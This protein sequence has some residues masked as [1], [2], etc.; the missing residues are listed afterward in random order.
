ME[1]LTAANVPCS[2][3][4]DI[5]TA[6]ADPQALAREMVQ[7]ID[8]PVTGRIPLLGPV[9]KLSGTPAK[10]RRALPRFWVNIRKVCCVNYLGI[11][12]K[13][14]SSSAP[15]GSFEFLV[16]HVTSYLSHRGGA[17]IVRANYRWLSYLTGIS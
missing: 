10:I 11:V 3:V 7:F 2:P 13:K 9:P 1:R 4:N 8:H 14:L 16:S 15:M 5:P 17:T 12:L 6:L